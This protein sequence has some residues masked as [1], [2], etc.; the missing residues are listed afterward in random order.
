M[1]YKIETKCVQDGWKP[2]NGE[3]RVLPICQ[4]TTFKYDSG[5]L[6]GDMFDLKTEGH[7]YTRLSNP[8]LE[9]VENKIAALEV[10]VGA[11]ITSS[12]QA[13]I[14]YAIFNICSAGD[15]VI[16]TANV[17]GGTFNLF[18]V[19]MEKMGIEVTFIDQDTSEENFKKAFKS[20]TKAVYG[21]VL[22]N[23]ALSVLD[24]EKFAKLAHEHSV[25][26]II[27]N[28]FPT[29]IN[30]RPIEWGADVVVHSTSKYMDGHAT[31]LG[32]VVVDSG[33]FDWA[34]SKKF[35]CL[36]EPDESYHGIIY[37][38]SFGNGAY[39]AK[40]RLQLMRDLG[41]QASPMNAFLLNMGLETLHLRM[42]RHSENALALAKFFENHKNVEWVFYPGLKSNK[43]YNLA[44]KYIPTGQ[45]GVISVGIKGGKEG[46]LAF[47]KKL[48]LAALVVHVAD[49][50]TSA[51]HPASTT[52]RQLSEQQL[53]ECN[54]P[55]EMVR[56]S[57]GIEHI[58][59][60]IADFKQA[61]D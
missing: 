17:Y 44:Q 13:A 27:D 49:L 47:M 32:G 52:H 61:L 28:T 1:S 10:G 26:L 33:N 37:T 36:T 3:P 29:P 14:F 2:Q 21:E 57:T 20:N 45:S 48:K 23:P 40:A 46:A 15:H 12:G 22:A 38:E 7:F 30:C 39:I 59:D 9:A 43:Y 18:G 51:L 53:K 31:A 34:K 4:S 6:L 41:A 5:E 35:S 42:E 11:M 24:I 58:E 8:T 55:P 60:I 25:P 54:V 50:R 56:I 19:T 16:S